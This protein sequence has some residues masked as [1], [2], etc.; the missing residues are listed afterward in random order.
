MDSGSKLIII[1][2]Q[3]PFSAIDITSASWFLARSTGSNPTPMPQSFDGV[4][5]LFLFFRASEAMSWCLSSL[6]VQQSWGAHR[7]GVRRASA[8]HYI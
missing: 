1:R 4:L 5:G 8:C 7:S 2:E 6:E 3:S